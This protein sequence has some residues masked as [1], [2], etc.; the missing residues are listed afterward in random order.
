M[1]LRSGPIGT[2]GANAGNSSTAPKVDARWSLFEEAKASQTKAG[3]L[4]GA[5]SEIAAE[6]FKEGVAVILQRWT[7]YD[8]ALTNGWGGRSSQEKGDNFFLELLHWFHGGTGALYVDELE[9]LLDEV[10]Q[11]DFNTVCDDGSVRQVAEQLLKLYEDVG[12]GNMA[13]VDKLLG[14]TK[15]SAAKQS[16]S[17]KKQR[18]ES[19]SVA[20]NAVHG[21]EDSEEDTSSEEEEEEEAGGA[22]ATGTGS[23]A[24]ES[25]AQEK[26]TR[27]KPEKPTTD[28]DG[29]TTLPVKNNR[30]K[31]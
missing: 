5:D 9:E 8:L 22:G 30:R 20:R 15:T 3:T 25:S 2:G 18:G 31:R 19:G 24:M 23:E 10:L 29:W 26:S 17:M 7:A 12:R 21:G 1:E 27:R 11:N 16:V 6:K 13:E 4:S 28:E 14:S